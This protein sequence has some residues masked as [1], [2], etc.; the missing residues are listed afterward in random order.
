MSLLSG[1]GARATKG[2]LKDECFTTLCLLGTTS[3]TFHSAGDVQFDADLSV[4]GDQ[5]VNGDL[6]VLG[7]LNAAV[8]TTI[9]DKTLCLNVLPLPTLPTDANADGGGLCLI[10]DTKKTIFWYDADDAWLFNQDVNL[11]QG[12]STIHPE[13]N[14]IA[15]ADY[16]INGASVLNATTLGAGVT[17]SSLTQ[18]GLLR[19]GGIDTSG[20]IVNIASGAVS[21]VTTDAPHGMTTGDTVRIKTSDS[22]PNINGYHT[23]TVISDTI[24]SVPVATVANGTTGTYEGGGFDVKTGPS[25]LQTG[26]IDLIGGGTITLTDT[27]DATTVLLDA[28]EGQIAITEQSGTSLVPNLLSQSA[29][30]GDFAGDFFGNSIEHTFNS[31][32]TASNSNA[33]SVASEYTG[34]NATYTHPFDT[35]IHSAAAVQNTATQTTSIATAIGLDA[36]VPSDQDGS[37]FGAVLEADSADRLNVGGLGL[38]G[39]TDTTPTSIGLWGSVN[40]TRD[41]LGTYAEATWIS[42]TP[43]HCGVLGYNPLTTAGQYAMCAVGNSIFDGDVTVTGTLTAGATGITA[44]L[45]PDTDNA[46]DIGSGTFRF[47]DIYYAGTLNGGSASLENV[48]PAAD[49]TYDLGSAL[50][51]WNDINYCG[52]LTGG[53]AKLEDTLPVADATY[54]LGSALFQWQD[55]HYAGTLNG[56]AASLESVLPAADCTYDLGSALLRW[57]DIHYCGALTG[58]SANLEHTLPTV[59]ATYDL[60]SGVSQWRDIYFSGTLYGGTFNLGQVTIGRET[61]TAAATGPHVIDPDIGVTEFTVTGTDTATMAAAATLGA[62]KMIVIDSLVGAVT[63]TVTVTG[64]INGTTLTF[65]A[66]GQSAL[67]LSTASGWCLVPGGAVL[68]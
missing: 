12:K 37:G 36:I 61:I 23:V 62:M 24:F 32:N 8:S 31:N 1:A 11:A 34:T 28:A 54:D 63:L 16:R 20:N 29:Y 40:A 58:G 27:N 13:D 68:A 18:V 42:G 53:S 56:G 22:T 41:D 50:L 7:T 59:D 67:F 48:L 45:I 46:Y 17:T 51:R 10:G 35:L 33:L 60:G 9:T 26:S 38:A 47:K 64:L 52:V 39:A 25:E 4:L 44:D 65:D 14:T 66:T 6:T 49:C 5:I 2:Y 57:N 3:P 55:I 43:T 21:T 30:T 19:T 15:G